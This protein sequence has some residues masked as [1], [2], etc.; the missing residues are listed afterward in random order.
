MHR[1]LA[2]L[3]LTLGL[4]LTLVAAPAH[5]QI[6]DYADYQPQTRCA[7]APKPGTEVLAR[8]LVR[9]LGGSVGPL[10]RSCRSGGTSEHKEGR[11]VDWTLDATTKRGRAIAKAFLGIVFAAD[12]RG[13]EDAKARR[14]GIMY[15]IWNDHMWSAWDGF[16]KDGYLSSSCRRVS[17][18]ST[19]LRHR[20]HM[21]ISLSRKGGKGLTSFYAGRVG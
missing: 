14:I 8:W 18:C 20:D 7:P 13:N 9:N 11:A 21:H 1:I 12:K 4:S 15:V 2:A 16:E 3:V 17:R 10:S 19:T 5:A 6:E